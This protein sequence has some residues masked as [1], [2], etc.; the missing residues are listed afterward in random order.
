MNRE[1][2]CKSGVVLAAV[3]EVPWSPNLLAI[4]RPEE[5]NEKAGRS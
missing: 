5:G 2:R 4:V 1:R 3:I